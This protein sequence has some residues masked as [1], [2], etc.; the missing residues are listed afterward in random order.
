MATSP[1]IET[2]RLFIKPF[3]EKFLNEKYV[4][5]LNDPD[6]V[7]FSEQRFTPHTLLSC[8]TY[9]EAFEGTPHYFWAILLKNEQQCH[10]GN[11]YAMLDTNNRLA[12]VGILLGEKKQ[13]GKGYGSEV[14]KA[15]ID[16]LFQKTEVR[17]ITA[18]TLAVNTGMLNIMKK[19]GMKEDGRRIRHYLNDGNEIDVVYAAIFKITVST[20]QADFKT[21][22]K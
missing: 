10:I 19:A 3:S 20:K 14:F 5:W 16:F 22:S 2:E 4:G 18:G 17:K 8:R 15:V 11:I 9:M 21:F 13:W 7:R 12:D 6:V 1:D